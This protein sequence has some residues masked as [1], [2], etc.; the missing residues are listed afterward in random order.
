MQKPNP[1]IIHAN[2]SKHLCCFIEEWLV[3]LANSQCTFKLDTEKFQKCNKLQKIS[4]YHFLNLEFYSRKLHWMLRT[5]GLEFKSVEKLLRMLVRMKMYL[6]S[7]ESKHSLDFN[8]E[9]EICGS[10]V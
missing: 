4:H 5:F 3:T 8:N 2:L 6:K 1:S 10:A 9:R 7:K